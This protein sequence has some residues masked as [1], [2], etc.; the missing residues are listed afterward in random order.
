M[1]A[2]VDIAGQE[3]IVEYDFTIT[4][5][6]YPGSG[7]SFNSPGQPPEPAE[8]EIEVLGARFPKQHADVPDLELPRWLKDALTTHLS[9][10]DDIN[11]IVQAADG[12]PDY[13]RDPDYERDLR[14]EDRELFGSAQHDD[15]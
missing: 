11:D 10:R 3:L 6:G 2:S 12:D 9:E 1:E 14:N 8:F 5:H 7:P 15:D 13:G 4:S